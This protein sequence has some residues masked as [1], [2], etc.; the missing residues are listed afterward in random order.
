LVIIVLATGSGG[1]I[2]DIPVIIVLATRNVGSI[3]DIPVIL[4]QTS[5]ISCLRAHFGIRG[6]VWAV[7][8]QLLVWEHAP[9][10][11]DFRHI[12]RVAQLY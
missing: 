12:R 10:T 9:S 5:H 8:S 7:T 2:L 1:S 11:T 3:L 4:G 6:I